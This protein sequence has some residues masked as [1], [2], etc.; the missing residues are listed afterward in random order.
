M[1]WGLL[2]IAAGLAA[3]DPAP[4]GIVRGELLGWKGE[5]AAG[6]F[7][8]LTTDLHIF[9]F[10][11]DHLTYFERDAEPTR[12]GQMRTGDRIEVVCD[13]GPSTIVGYARSVHVLVRPPVPRGHI[14][15]PKG[16][17][18]EAI[19]PRG[20]LTLAGLVV[21]AG[22]GQ[23][24]LRLRKGEEKSVILRKDTVYLENGMVVDLASLKVNTHVFVRAGANIDDQL[25]AYRVIW[26]A[27]LM[28]DRQ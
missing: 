26:G 17:P 3:Q 21:R 9:Q 23:L 24:V 27:I 25:E 8:I 12:I 13:R 4:V 7:S 18:T 14:D 15:W 6:Q 5:A 28:P 10:S 1:R 11:F 22:S 20:S 16:D 19:V 2:V